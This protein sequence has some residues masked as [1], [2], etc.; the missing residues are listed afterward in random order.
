MS[1]GNYEGISIKEAME[2]IN[3]KNNG[4]F[5]P[6]VQR[7][8]VW[9]NRESS[10]EYICLLVDSLMRGF[11]IGGLVL[12]ETDEPV[13]YR[14]FLTDYEV[15]V[16]A[17]IVS[18]ETWV[19]HKFLVY[20]G[21]QRLQTLHSILY[22][23]FNGRVLYYDLLFNPAENEID[24][25]GFFFKN[26]EEQVSETSIALPELTG[27]ST[28]E[29]KIQLRRRLTKNES[30]TEAELNLIETNFDR[31]WSVFVG[32]EL[33]SIAYFPVRSNS[34]QAVNEVFRRLNTGG[35]SLTQ[36]EMV[37]AK[38]KE[39]SPYFEETLWDLTKKIKE[40]TGTPG[41][42]FSAHEIVQLIY[43]LVFHTN[44]VDEGKVN[45]N[46]VKTLVDTLE[47]VQEV[48]PH[49]F[50]YF[51]FEGFRINANWLVLRQQAILPI[52]AY[53]VI[54]AKNGYKWKP[55]Q[56]DITGIRTYFIK[57]QLCDW[58]TQTM[59][60]QFSRQTMDCASQNKPFPLE[61]IT[62]IAIEKN[63]TGDVYL[64]Q[65]EGPLWFSLKIL[66]PDRE[67]LFNE[68]TP[69]IDHIFPMALH[70]GTPEAEK[71]RERVNV[72]WNMQPTPA[73]INNHKRCKSPQ[74]Y[75][76]S[77]G[78]PFF[79]CYDFLPEL[80]AEN[81][82]NAETFISYRKAQML[83]FMTNRYGIEI[84]ENPQKE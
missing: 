3:A 15:G 40:A 81:W 6:H 78:K 36:L 28:S 61:K 37:L 29:G 59:V 45:S 39:Q 43:L 41:Y 68:R 65:L 17:K 9:G 32:T 52:L 82:K 33:R 60:T 72:L 58:N 25:T 27:K 77:E 2:K 19:N 70:D 49:F 1:Q 7:Q 30:L 47:C 62:D 55:E 73:G 84:K 50:K 31:L 34:P 21:Q 10:E 67:Y 44:R 83:V 24:E 13:P 35:I 80:D 4:W 23:R 42:S 66:T 74:N 75:F 69:Q 38:I 8:Y 71:Y 14:Q 26:K 76:N 16:T 51:F 64:Y 11:P 20:D 12:W 22:Y 48:L 56:I 54:L 57:S 53:F 46:N 63:R 18:Q 5:L 79:A